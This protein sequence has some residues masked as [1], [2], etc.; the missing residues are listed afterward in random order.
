MPGIPDGAYGTELERP[1]ARMDQDLWCARALATTPRPTFE[2]VEKVA[3]T[4]R[5]LGIAPMQVRNL[6]TT[7]R[8]RRS[9][10]TEQAG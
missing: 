10:F 8:Q 2:V 4:Q 1:G 5:R 9:E 3:R 6:S 7:L